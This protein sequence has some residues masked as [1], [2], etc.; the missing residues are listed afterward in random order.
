MKTQIALPIVHPR[1]VSILQGNHIQPT[2]RDDGHIFCSADKGHIDMSFKRE[3]CKSPASSSKTKKDSDIH[4][5]ELFLHIASP[6]QGDLRLSGS[7]SVAGLEQRRKRPSRSQD[8]CAT[9]AHSRGISV[10]NV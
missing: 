1:R 6:Q 7:P 10:L 8:H 9:D 5:R 3:T 4:S 2:G